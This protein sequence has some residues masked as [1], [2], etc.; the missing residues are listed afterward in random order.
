MITFFFYMSLSTRLEDIPTI[1]EWNLNNRGSDYRG[2]TVWQDRW[3]FYGGA[4][5]R[6]T[7]TGRTRLRTDCERGFP[8]FQPIN[9]PRRESILKF[10]CENNI[11][12]R[13]TS[14][15]R[16]GI[17]E[18]RT[19]FA[20]FFSPREKRAN[21]DLILSSRSLTTLRFSRLKK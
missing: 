9:A 11:S 1:R 15:L 17:T 10:N 8:S 18:T 7:V 16:N 2:S 20:L 4:I 19:V 13:W 3:L 14:N 5:I 21:I 6:A 12:D